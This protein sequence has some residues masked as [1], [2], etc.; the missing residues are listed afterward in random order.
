[1]GS[2][3]SWLNTLD[4]TVFEVI[5]KWFTSGFFDVLMPQISAI[6]VWVIPFGIVWIVFFI[7][8]NRRGRLIALCC[9]LVVGATDQLSSNVVKPIVQRTRPCNVVP[10]THFYDDGKWVTTD[11][12]APQMGVIY[13]SSYSFPSSHAANVAGQA[14]YWSYFFPQLSPA[15]IAAAI[16][17][18]F[19][20]I[21]L[22][23]HWPTDVAA[24]YLLGVLVALLIA[25]PMRVWVLPEE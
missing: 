19:S 2:E 16:V 4:R 1:V 25:Y 10:E 13:K 11:K 9:F 18:G 20:R 21:Y 14:M 15:L 7:R 3:L 8:T 24:G 17:V 23:V 5:N 22:G 6:L 12:F